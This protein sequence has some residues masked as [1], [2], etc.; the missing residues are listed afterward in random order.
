MN[1]ALVLL[2]LLCACAGAGAVEVKEYD[3]RL[4]VT[5]DGT[6]QASVALTVAG[7]RAGR[8]RLPVGFAAME[9]FTPSDVPSGVVLTPRASKEQSY[10]DIEFPN[11]SPADTKIGFTFRTPGVLF[12]P[13]PEEGQKSTLPAGSRVLRH[14]FVNTQETPIASYRLRVRLPDEAIVHMIREQ[15]PKPRRKEFTP[16]VELDRFDGSQGAL[17][18]FSGLRQGDRTSMELEVVEQRRS[19]A[20]LLV[21]LPI[22][23][24]YLVA[25]RDTVKPQS[26]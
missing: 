2:V 25:F 15:L 9:E 10:V 8:L 3:T 24:G 11:D 26:A 14:S 5:A 23:L 20:W 1:K 13:K 18:Q 7:A 19:M 12:A 16:R 21:L 4:D 17:L 22:A 6:A